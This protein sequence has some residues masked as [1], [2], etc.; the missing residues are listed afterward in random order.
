M[1]GLLKQWRVLI[2]TR[3]RLITYPRDRLY[4]D[5]KFK[6]SEDQAPARAKP[7]PQNLAVLHRPFTYFRG[8]FSYYVLVNLSTL[9]YPMTQTTRG[10]SLVVREEIR[11][12]LDAV[13]SENWFSGPPC[14][15]F[16]CWP[17]RFIAKPEG[18]LRQQSY[19]IED[20]VALVLSRLLLD[21]QKDKVIQ[22]A[23]P[24]IRVFW[25]LE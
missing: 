20:G 18:S 21:S 6:Y 17:T 24:S 15:R 13:K 19:W 3:I 7:S 23:H 25:S 14:G 5:D 22:R 10:L 8:G 4:H 16:K 9:Y 11:P 12:S 1:T 2:L